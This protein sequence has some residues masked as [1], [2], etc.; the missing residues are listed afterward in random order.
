M[1]ESPSE[2]NRPSPAPE[3]NGGSDPSSRDDRYLVAARKYRPALFKEVVAQQHVTDTLKNALKLD[4]LAHAY[5][6]SGPRGVGK[7]TTARILAKA[8]N[9]ETPRE[10]REDESE[11]CRECDSCQA[12]EAGRSLNVFEMDAASNNKVDDI[13]ELRETVRIPPQGSTKK[14]YILDE[15]HMLSTQAF[16]ALLKTLEEP[17]P[18]ALFIFAT[19]EP[20]KVLPTILSRCQRFDFR[21]IPVP[22]IVDHLRRICDNEG[23]EADEESLMLLARKGDGALRDALS[24][25]D[26]AISLCGTTL[27]YG[28]LTQAL[29]VVDQ[30]LF[31]RLTDHVATQDTAGVLKLVNHIVRSGY[32]LQEFLGGLAEHVRNLLVAR[33]LGDDAL[34]EVAASTRR[35]Y[36]EEAKRFGEADLLRLLTVAGDAEDDVKSSSQPR[37]KLE[38]ALLK[39]AQMRRAADLKT[40]LQK[41]DR[42]EQMVE[43]GEIPDTLPTDP[44]AASSTT[45][46][47]SAPNDAGSPDAPATGTSP[48]DGTSDAPPSSNPPATPETSGAERSGSGPSAS[49]PGDSPGSEDAAPSPPEASAPAADPASGAPAP[50]DSAPDESSSPKASPEATSSAKSSSEEPSSEES[51]SGRDG[52]SS[53]SAGA[54]EPSSSSPEASPAAPEEPDDEDGDLPEAPDDPGFTT[55]F[56]DEEDDASPDSGG[57]LPAGE[58]TDDPDDGGVGYGD[59]FG[60]PALDRKSGNGGSPENDGGS[61]PSTDNSDAPSAGD[62]SQTAEASSGVSYGDGQAAGSA[63]TS[64]V[65]EPSPPPPSSGDAPGLQA[66][67]SA[68]TSFVQS[69]M[70]EKISLGALL[71]DAEATGFN[72]RTLTISAPKSL[73]RDQF[74]THQRYLLQTLQKVVDAEIESLEFIVD[75]TDTSEADQETEETLD[76]QKKMERL[77]E[78]YPALDRLFDQFG[79]ELVW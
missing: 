9:C 17:P 19:T 48:S 31:F 56:D 27:E 51:S 28:D 32:D 49:S 36:A 23:I 16:N 5:L 57:G 10:E 24:A 22:R 40:V 54:Q 34:E 46:S 62:G 41:I 74:R 18:H 2:P 6:F 39:M 78:S 1:A 25:F 75:R 11:P 35:R 61:A 3:S 8:I 70:S 15:V 55:P 20:H 76:P 59:L 52:A 63:D 29:G 12:F 43:D 53:P 77:R 66:V 73:H 68:W 21:R 50:D 69:V 13:R 38:M 14:V 60:T 45:A 65:T 64:V 4:R 44:G 58:E 72:G 71:G 7:T 33:S 37:L 30:D 42:L 47:A 26:Q 79:A 67:Q